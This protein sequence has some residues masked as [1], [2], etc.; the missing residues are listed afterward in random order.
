MTT[1]IGVKDMRTRSRKRR[2]CAVPALVVL[3]L[4]GAVTFAAELAELIVTEREAS[5][6]RDKR[7]YSPRV[8]AVREG[9]KV[10]LLAREDP[11]LRVE[12]RGKQGWMTASSV[13]DDPKI[14]LSN[15][16]VPSGVRV[17]EQSA[18][19][20]GFTPEVEKAYRAS[21]SELEFVFKLLD[22][23]EKAALAEEKVVSFL[24]EGRLAGFGAGGGQ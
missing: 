18:G 13:S 15:E 14:V 19:G 7:N 2:R 5:V 17:S 16:V 20:R 22:A 3:L 24:Q 10:A 6:R 21:H 23:L 8:A 9:E 1:T 11:W 12:Y 4:V